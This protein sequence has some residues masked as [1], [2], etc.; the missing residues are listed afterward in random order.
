MVGNF[1]WHA[2][3]PVRLTL[4]VKGRQ[5]F[6]RN[7]NLE[8]EGLLEEGTVSVDVSQYERTRVEEEQEEDGV[9]FSDSD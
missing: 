1:S 9:T 7:R 8:E 2:D 3:Y 5:L 6:E 4:D